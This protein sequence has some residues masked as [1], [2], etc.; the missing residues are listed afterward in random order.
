MRVEVHPD[1]LEFARSYLEL[2]DVAGLN[3]HAAVCLGQL[4][5]LNATDGPGYRRLTTALAITGAMMAGHV[6]ELV[7]VRRG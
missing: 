1:D 2:R 5:S 4:R 7:A 3:W 6:P